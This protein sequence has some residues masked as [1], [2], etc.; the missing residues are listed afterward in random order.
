VEIRLDPSEWRVV[1]QER[2]DS[3]KSFEVPTEGYVSVPRGHED[4]PRFR[5]VRG[6]RGSPACSTRKGD[7]E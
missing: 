6:L 4:S 2:Q 3:S 5:Q 7:A 1:I